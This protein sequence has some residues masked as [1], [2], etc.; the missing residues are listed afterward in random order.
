MTTIATITAVIW[1]AC[2]ILNFGIM[3][4]F[5]QRKWPILAEEDYQRDY[6]MCAIFSILGPISL[7]I[8]LVTRTC[9]YGLKWK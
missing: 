4:A 3:F 7:L 6:A 1:I 2:A 8:S 9:G 5:F